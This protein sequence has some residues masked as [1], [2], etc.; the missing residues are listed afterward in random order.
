M[1]HSLSDWSMLQT[2]HCY[3]NVDTSSAFCKLNRIQEPTN[4]QINFLWL[5]YE[6]RL[7]ELPKKLTFKL[8]QSNKTINCIHSYCSLLTNSKMGYQLSWESA[9]LA[10]KMSTVRSC[11]TVSCNYEYALQLNSLKGLITKL[12]PVRRWVSNVDN[13]WLT[14]LVEC[15]SCKEVAIRSNRMLGSMD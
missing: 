6:S 7:L 2:I 9:C 8:T 13:A 14:Q 4:K 15:F 3:N 12:S 1:K 5:V 11:D 10:R